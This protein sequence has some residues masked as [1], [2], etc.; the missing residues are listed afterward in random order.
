MAVLGAVAL[1]GDV[2]PEV[3]AVGG[4]DDGLVKVRFRDNPIEPAVENLLVGMCFAITP[5]SVLGDRDVDV[6]GFSKDVLR[7]KDSSDFEVELWATVAA[8][9]YNRFIVEHLT[10]EYIGLDAESICQGME[11][12]LDADKRRFLGKNGRVK[13]LEWYDFRVMWPLVKE[14][15]ERIL[16]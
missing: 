1:A 14:L 7:G 3:F 8:T 16:K 12:M 9:Y 10:G 11:S 6:A 13:V 2:D 15:Y 5:R 4:F